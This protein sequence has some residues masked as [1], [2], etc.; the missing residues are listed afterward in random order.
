MLAAD[1]IP[2]PLVKDAVQDR[3]IPAPFD[4]QKIDG[5]I[6]ERMRVNLEGR[7][8]HIDEKGLLEGFQQRPG[9][10]VWIGEHAGKFL[11]AASNTWLYSHDE[12]LK[13]IMDRMARALIAE[14]L[15][16]GYQGTYTA[17][18]RWTAWD[19]WVHK[20]RFPAK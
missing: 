6:G 16:D 2:N 9:K 7:L 20:Y 19:V 4:R 18:K 14:Q 1:S 10:Q 15:P 13:T 12:R 11:H 5:L 8:L 3:F 17:D